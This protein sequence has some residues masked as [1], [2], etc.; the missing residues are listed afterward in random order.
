MRMTK[1]AATTDPMDRVRRTYHDAAGRTVRSIEN[2][3]DGA[4]SDA[5]D[6]T[7]NYT[8]NAAG[9]TS[10]VNA[11]VNAIGA[12]RGVQSREDVILIAHVGIERV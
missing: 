10:L 6:K 9:M 3:V 2:F 11:H 1:L 7:V 4:V 8:Y 12:T 5:D